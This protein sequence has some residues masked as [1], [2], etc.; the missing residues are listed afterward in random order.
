MVELRPIA[1]RFG[2]SPSAWRLSRNLDV[3]GHIVSYHRSFKG[4]DES[5]PCFC[6]LM[7]VTGDL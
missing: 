6:W 5:C 7:D 2:K 4:D 3:G 1:I